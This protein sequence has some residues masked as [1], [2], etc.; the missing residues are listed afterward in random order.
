MELHTLILFVTSRCNAR[1]Q[2]C[3]YWKEL[4]RDGDLTFD[5]I[6]RLSATMP[7]FHELYLSGGEPLMR[8]RLDEI[9]GMFYERNGVRTLNLPTNGL[10]EGRAVELMER[11]GTDMPELD[12]NLNVALDGFADTHDEIRGVPGNFDR[13]LAMIEALYPVRERHPSV[14]IHVNSVITAANLDELEELGWWMVE[15]ADL[16]GHYFQVIRG[17]AKNPELKRLDRTRLTEFYARVRPIHDHYARRLRDR[18]GG[19]KGRLKRRY[20]RETILFHYSVQADNLEGSSRWPMPCTAG[21][22]ILVIDYDGDVRAC[23]LRRPLANLRDVGCDFSRLF[24]SGILARETEQIVEDQCWCTHVCFIHE[25][26]K[27]SKRVRYFDIPFGAKLAQGVPA[28][29][30]R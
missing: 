22:T 3:F 8:D 13:A 2:T 20:Y 1:C 9:V 21:E 16:D 25:S 11:C 30:P 23:E 6:D 26:Q 28:A 5:E 17:D 10:F 4:N 29:S 15:H 24:P 7:R 19:L 18:H 14:R 27:R 12:V